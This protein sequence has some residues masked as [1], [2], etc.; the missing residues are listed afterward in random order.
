MPKPGVLF[1][2]D[3]RPCIKR[4][5]ASEKGQLFE[6]ILDYGEFGVEPELNGALGVAWDFIKP[7]LDADSERYEGKVL[8]RQYAVF[9]REAKNG[10]FS[11]C[12]S[13]IG[14][15]C[16]TSSGINRHRVISRDIQIQPQ[17][18]IQI[19]P[20]YPLRL[21]LSAW[22][23]EMTL[24]F[25]N[26]GRPVREKPGKVRHKRPL[27]GLGPLWMFFFQP[28]SSRNAVTNGNATEG[29]IF[30]TRQLG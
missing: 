12:A 1:Y 9:V 14:R 28:W 7:R 27:R 23:R 15:L 11:R 4:L 21:R 10:A 6:A 25:L 16:P 18:Q 30:H 3:I 19:Q 2:F 17:I 5:S 13:M 22:T 20:L 8:Q 24:P 29:D 26:S